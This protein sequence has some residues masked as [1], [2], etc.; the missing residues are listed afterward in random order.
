MGV[1]YCFASALGKI[2]YSGC[3]P[4]RCT[5]LL[6]VK[7]CRILNPLS[8]A[9]DQTHSLM[10][11]SRICSSL[12]HDGNS[13]FS[14]F[15]SLKHFCFQLFCPG[16][17]LG[18]FCFQPLGGL[19]ARILGFHPGCPDSIPEQGIKIF[20]CLFVFWFVVAGGGGG[21]HLCLTGFPRL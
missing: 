4:T 3:S 17:E 12:S 21:L 16:Q 7:I 1:C 14:S 6:T 8:K 5:L 15:A 19:V 9:R 13:C 10:V 20:V 11:P 18:P 2:G